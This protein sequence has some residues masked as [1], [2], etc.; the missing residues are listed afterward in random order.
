MIVKLA[1]TMTSKI[2]RIICYIISEYYI[3]LPFWSSSGL[4][5][6]NVEHLHTNTSEYLSKIRVGV[7]LS[8]GQKL[9]IKIEECGSPVQSKS[10]I[11]EC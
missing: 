2:M 11:E 9:G 7:R 4:V 1:S 5:D 8:P 3:T 10:K 6:V